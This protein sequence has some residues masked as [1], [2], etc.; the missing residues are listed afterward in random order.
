[1][2]GHSDIPVIIKYSGT[3]NIF[4]AELV[5]EEEKTIRKV[6]N[7]VLTQGMSY[8]LSFITFHF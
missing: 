6:D 1:M 7:V 5:L 4:I 2:F 3:L 8:E